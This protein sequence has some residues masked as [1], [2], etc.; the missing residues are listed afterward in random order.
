[1]DLTP[2]RLRFTPAYAGNIS[3]FLLQSTTVQVHPRIRGEYSEGNTKPEDE[4][5]SPPHTRGIYLSDYAGKNV[6]RFT[7]AY[8]GNIG[9]FVCACAQ[10]QVHP[11]IRGEYSI[12][13]KKLSTILGSPPHTRG[14]SNDSGGYTQTHRFT[15]AY[16]GN[17][18]PVLF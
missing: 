7:P 6:I 14:I 8:A 3:I 16:A 11:R 4:L 10:V 13:L 2:E 1:M 12:Y 5:G 9:H 15:P 18:L 17:I